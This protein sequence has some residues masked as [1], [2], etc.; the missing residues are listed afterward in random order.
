MWIYCSIMI[1]V[2]Y[3]PG[4]RQEVLCQ[5]FEIRFDYINGMP[6]HPAQIDAVQWN[7]ALSLLVQVY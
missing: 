7:L 4:I 6:E 1:G 3:L 2:L 5:I